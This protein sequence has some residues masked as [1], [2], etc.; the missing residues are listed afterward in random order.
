MSMEIMVNNLAILI[1]AS[2]SSL[3]PSKSLK[4]MA[5]LD[6]VMHCLYVINF[7]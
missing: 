4:I 7:Q 5:R 1:T 6:F 2:W 3:N